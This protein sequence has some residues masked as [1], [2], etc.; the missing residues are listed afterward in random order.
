MGQDTIIPAPDIS[1]RSTGE[2]GRYLAFSLGG[3]DFA[4]PLL[5]VREVIAVTEITEVPHM[6]AYFQGI[7]SLR[8]QIISI[9]DLKT[10]FQ[11]KV[12]PEPL[13]SAIVI[14][15]LHPLCLGVV[16]DAVNSV[17]TL[18]SEQI[19]PAPALDDVGSQHV[20]GVARID[21]KLIILLDIDKTLSGGDLAAI[22]SQTKQINAA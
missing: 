20:L 15:D 16:V 4:V 18:S 7:M 11:M 14:L 13:E 5:K 21:K 6:P 8:G 22:K 2:G 1:Q 17:M 12:P 10:K 3:K 19:S 9:I